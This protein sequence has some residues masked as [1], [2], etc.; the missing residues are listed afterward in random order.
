MNLHLVVLHKRINMINVV[1]TAVSR[2]CYNVALDDTIYV[3]SNLCLES[4]DLIELS[5]HF[6][7]DVY[8]QPLSAD[9]AHALRALPDVVLG[10]ARKHPYD[11]NMLIDGHDKVKKARMT[12]IPSYATQ[13]K[14]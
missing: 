12:I 2:L 6:G 3:Y 13:F 10:N 11:A 8:L 1:A 14:G 4:R 5:T 7:C 9:D